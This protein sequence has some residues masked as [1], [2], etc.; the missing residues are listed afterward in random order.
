[1]GI[2][3]RSIEVC[4]GSKEVSNETYIEHFRKQDKD[5]RHLLE[6]VLGRDKRYMLD[7][8]ETT[9]TLTINAA[10]AA[11]E[12]ADLK[13][14]DIDV[15][16]YSSVLA[17]Y[18]LPPTT[19]ILHEELGLKENAVCFDMNANCAGM[20][21]AMENICNY[22]VASKNVKRALVIG[23]DNN[24]ALSDPNNELCYGN[25]GHAACA[26]VLDKVD[27]ACGLINSEF[28]INTSV[29]DKIRCPRNGFSSFFKPGSTDNLYSKWLPFSTEHL[30]DES[31]NMIER[32]IKDAG[33]TKD[34]ISMF[35]LSQLTIKNTERIRELMDIGEDKSIYIGNK[36]G[37]TGTTSP[38]IVLYEAINQGKIKRGDY[39]VIWTFG[40]GSQGIAMIYKY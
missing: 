19:I 1:M 6:D 3:L 11:L 9:L 5:V 25:F 26:I 24:H 10:K 8:D 28:Y 18:I 35:C 4:H 34:D 39:I 37:Y 22:L 31:V 17:E 13:G 21:V 2:K 14:S 12:K 29:S 40:A 33:L 7:D 15:L 32:I 27:E 38:F 20:G 16:V 23:C 30:I 36:Y